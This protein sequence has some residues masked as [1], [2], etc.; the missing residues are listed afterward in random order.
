MGNDADTSAN[1]AGTKQ[2]PQDA[3]RRIGFR[4]VQ[5]LEKARAKAPPLAA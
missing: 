5:D 4:L 1:K 3:P 2:T